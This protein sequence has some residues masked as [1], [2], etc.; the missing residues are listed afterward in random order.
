[1]SKSKDKKK[2]KNDDDDD[3][4]KEDIEFMSTNNLFQQRDENKKNSKF[5]SHITYIS[6]MEYYIYYK[7]NLAKD[8]NFED[9]CGI[10]FC[11]GY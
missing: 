5:E 8:P 9:R 6:P 1:M 10:C 3:E 2:A 11:E 4:G 7:A